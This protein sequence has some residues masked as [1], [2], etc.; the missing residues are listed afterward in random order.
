M[1]LLSDLRNL[2]ARLRAKRYNTMFGTA[3]IY[4]VVWDD[5][6]IRVLEVDGTYQSATYVDDRWCDIPFPYL[7]L[8]DCMFQIE[9]A[10]KSICMLGGGGYA[11]PKHVVAHRSPTSIDVVEIDPVITSLAKEYFYLDR[12]EKT[13]HAQRDGRLNLVCNDAIAYLRSCM[14]SDVRY[15]AIVNDCFAAGSPNED[16]ATSFGAALLRSCL[17]PGGLYLTNVITALAGDEAQPLADLTDALSKQFA[18][19]AAI[20]CNRTAPDDPDNVVVVASNCK[21][22]LPDA[23]RVFDQIAPTCV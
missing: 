4:E 8:Y 22:D 18:H 16:L 11:F 1:G 19:I 17:A 5:S 15:D 2:C 14:Q 13:Y 21:L 20:P 9:R 12:L 3:R 6:R 7:G 10:P 23:I